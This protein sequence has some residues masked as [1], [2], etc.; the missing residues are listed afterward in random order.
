MHIYKRFKHRET[1]HMITVVA[2]SMF[3]VQWNPVN[4]TTNGPKYS[5]RINGVVVLPG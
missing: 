3:E 4:T 5:G 1:S 2:N